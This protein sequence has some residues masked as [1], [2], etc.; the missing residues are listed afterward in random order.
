MEI[1]VVVP[2]DTVNSI[3]EVYQVAADSIIYNNQLIYPYIL[4]PGQA[5]LLSTPSANT[6]FI[7]AIT[8]GYA[9]PFINT[10][11]LEQTLPYLSRLS[12]FSYGFT[13][14]GALI[15]PMVDDTFM[16]SQA[17]EYR[18]APFL[19]LTPF[20]ASGRFNNQLISEIIN[21]AQARN[22]LLNNLVTTVSEKGFQGVD[23]DFEYILAEDRIGFA[24]FVT[25]VRAAINELGYPVTVAL[26]PKTSDD[27]P[28]LLY[29]GK[30]YALL[31]EAA[32][33]VLL[34]TY[35]WGYTYGPPM[36]VAPINNVRRVVEYA[37]TRIPREKINL[38]IPN[39]G[40]D[41]PLPFVMGETAATTIGNIEAITIA[42]NNG[43]VIQF[44]ET[45]M[46]PF[47]TYTAN[48]I[49]HE[50]WFEDVRS[51]QAKFTLV[52][53]YQLKGMGYWQIMRLFRGNWLL[54]ADQFQIA[55]L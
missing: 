4:V 11:V 31:G 43:A 17:L 2:G 50:V 54:L 44:D 26:A 38:G 5:L 27:Q 19:T 23:I 24:E 39:Y 37:L 13:G 9:Y 33:E 34:M 53:E 3:A 48:G 12:I 18:T 15:P 21:N 7:P 10:W 55:K 30:D 51:M 40:Y 6:S 14:E 45:A 47:F 49:Q 29:E 22:Q 36:A 1:H 28:G 8:N 46:S 41:W 16:I 42:A 25:Q 35:E 20:D 32:D 52:K